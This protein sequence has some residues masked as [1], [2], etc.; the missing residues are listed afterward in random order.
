[1]RNNLK[2]TASMS[3]PTGGGGTCTVS[4]VDGHWHL[5]A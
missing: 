1:V 2:T 4:T 5:S 3:R